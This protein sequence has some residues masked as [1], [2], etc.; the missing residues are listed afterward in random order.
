MAIP[1]APGRPRQSVLIV[2]DDTLILRVVS[3]MLEGAGFQT[4]CFSSPL[5]AL[6]A[7][8]REQP[9]VIIADYVMPEVNGIAFLEMS[10]ARSPGSARILCSAY[11]DSTVA[12]QAVNAGQVNRIVPKPPRE[13]DLISAVSQAAETV[14]LRRRNEELAEQLR[15]QNLH[16][17]EIVRQRTQA[18]LWGFVESLDARDSSTKWHSQRVASYAR[19]LAAGMGIGEPELSV[20]ERGSLLHDI[21]KIAVPDRILLKEGPLSSEEWKL[22]RE[23][24][25]RG[26][27]LLQGVDYLRVASDVVLQHHERWDGK[28]YPSRISGEEIAVGARVFQVVDAYDAITTDRP[29]HQ[30]LTH[31]QARLEL[32][33]ASGTQFDPAVVAAFLAVSAEE[34]L[35]IRGV[36]DGLAAAEGEPFRIP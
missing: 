9:D 19:R 27:A 24:P 29:Y 10:I 36:V 34:W 7:V 12:M 8:E 15:R 13:V 4:H 3:G 17:E 5:E 33:R 6:A 11:T 2:D 20:I 18:L 28:G 16:L 25:R 35:A 22:M 23:H 21:G 31:D 1:D 14:L 32:E 26:W 30:A